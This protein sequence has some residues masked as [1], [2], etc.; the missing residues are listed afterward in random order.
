[1]LSSIGARQNLH[2]FGVT[3]C[4]SYSAVGVIICFVKFTH[5][6]DFLSSNVSTKVGLISWE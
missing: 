3:A 4:N 2:R 6:S 1:M 5:A